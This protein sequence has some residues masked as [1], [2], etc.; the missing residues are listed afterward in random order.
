VESGAQ[1]RPESRL[2]LVQTSP[3]QEVRSESAEGGDGFFDDNQIIKRGRWSCSGDAK[4]VL[5]RRRFGRRVPTSSRQS[6]ATHCDPA[7]AGSGRLEGR[8]IAQRAG[9][10]RGQDDVDLLEAL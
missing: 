1:W 9:V 8:G 5:E 2:Q 3:P 4:R 6:V 7:V 10:Q